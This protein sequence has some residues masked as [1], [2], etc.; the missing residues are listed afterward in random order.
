VSLPPS[1]WAS[2]KPHFAGYCRPLNSSLLDTYNA[3]GLGDALWPTWQVLAP[4]PLDHELQGVARRGLWLV[5]LWG[6]IPGEPCDSCLRDPT[7][8]HYVTGGSCEYR[9][10]QPAQELLNETRGE[11]AR[12][13]NRQL[14][15][16]TYSI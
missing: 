14:S 16:S 6:Y 5:D 10:T 12:D 4:A 7:A 8:P 1:G 11:T 2:A 9:I 13:A 3:S 15:T